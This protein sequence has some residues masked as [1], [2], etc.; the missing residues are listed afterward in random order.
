MNGGEHSPATHAAAALNASINGV[1][2]SIEKPMPAVPSLDT[3]RPISASG[4]T[5]VNTSGFA[6]VNAP[7][8]SGFTAVNTSPQTFIKR[9]GD[10]TP[11]P[12]AT[13]GSPGASADH[14]PGF[15]AV[16]GHANHLAPNPMKRALSHESTNGESMS[17]EANGDVDGSGRRSKR[18]KKDGAPTVAGSHMSLM[19]PST[20]RSHPKNGKRKPG[21]KCETCGKTED[22][23]SIIACDSCDQGHHRY[24]LDPPLDHVPDY[25]WN[26]PRC[27]VGTGEYG[28]EEG[29]VYSLK[30]FQEKANSFKE[31]YFAPR[32][33]FDPVLNTQKK[34]SEDEVEREF[35]R[36]VESLTETVEVEYGADIHS[37]THGSGFPTIERNP[38]D[39][40]SKDPWNLNVLPFHE[41]SL[42]RHIKTDVSGMTVPW[43]YVGMCFSTFCWHNEDHYAYSANYQHF[44]STKTWYGIP[45]SDAHAFE[46]AMRQAVPELF[47]TQPDL[48]FQLVTL[49]PPDQLKKAGVNVYALDQRAGQMVITFP[50]AYHAG[51]NHGFN[52]NEAVNFAPADWEPFGEAGV[53][54]LQ[55]FRRHPCFSHDE[56]LLTAASTDA[57]IKTAKWLGPALERMKVR[58]L[59]DRE[60]FLA[61]HK[62][63][64]P[65]ECKIDADGPPEET[66]G[67]CALHFVIDDADLA[68]DEYQC[69]YCKAYTYLSQFQCHQTSKVACLK[70]ADILDC[71][72]DEKASK[73]LGPNHTL[74]FRYPNAGLSNIVQKIVDKARIP[75]AW[76]ERLDNLLEDQPK[77]SLKALHSILS[78]GEKIPSFLPGLKDLADF[79]R[80]CDKWVEEA[81]SYVARKQQNRRK[82]DRVWR[83]S[84][85]KD[86]KLEEKDSDIRTLEKMELLIQ[87][88]ENLGFES[89]VMEQLNARMS[90]IADWRKE[91]REILRTPHIRSPTEIED[92]LDL[93]RSFNL[94]V[95]PEAE[96]LEKTL[97]RMTW[98]QEAKQYRDPTSPFSL[99]QCKDF[100]KRGQEIGIPE[101]NH[102]FLHFAEMCHQGDF[103]EL[104][105]TEIMAAEVVHYPQLEA[106]YNQV[107]RPGHFPINPETLKKMEGILTK[108]REAHRT[109][110]SLY[111]R[112]RDP[113]F[114]RRPTY[115]E[116]RDMMESLAELNS[117]PQGAMDLEREQKRHEDWMRKGK[118]L[119]GK[120]NAPLH[121]LKAHMQYVEDKNNYCFDLN[122]T[123]RPPVEPSSRASS[124]ARD[125]ARDG[126]SKSHLGEDEKAIFCIC[127]MPE[128]G[129]MIECEVCHDW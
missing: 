48:L 12:K 71:C 31:N 104:K 44:G 28:F 2:N 30:Q 91:A 63:L 5:P 99:Q 1:E 101:T 61:K 78:E 118:K 96:D 49:L 116:V 60:A 29:G 98:T 107:T 87:E 14:A 52:F 51:F 103:W 53:Q 47:E 93:A 120:A 66:S 26:C 126:A 114:Q 17:D 3:P 82:N 111:K 113:D 18:I 110:V 41:E 124:P 4:F 56:L 35:W 43:L 19:R 36:L 75:E 8:S 90:E 27:L 94:Q 33:P 34:V 122:D 6:A 127:R 123:F 76:Q 100:L 67:Q 80:R 128:A 16:N 69:H 102:D 58:E 129:M 38:T 22:R 68:E 81:N 50:Q 45:G 109:I 7:A 11:I 86:T 74:R 15:A 32:M 39:P 10:F 25:D 42:F 21:E 108:N 54:R 95:L 46:A 62:D 64:L 125:P 105:A 97:S 37:T 85:L 13:T 57:T 20:P 73:L 70:H 9:E 88:G 24:C 115:K 106:L 59:L 65:H 84:S 77:P 40:Y 72:S 119:F 89:P 117:K 79:V 55:E 92:F 23:D 83:K 112:S 121:I